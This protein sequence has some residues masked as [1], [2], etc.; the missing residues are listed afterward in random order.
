MS[1]PYVNFYTSDFLGGTSG[2]TA[3]TKGVYITL[4]CQMYESEAPLTQDWEILAR[5]AGCTKSAFKKA[6]EVLVDDGKL[7]VSEAGIW[8]SKCDKHIALRRERQNSASAA[9]KKR[10]EKIKQKQ[11]GGDKG[12]LPAQCQPEPEPYIE[13]EDTNVSSKK[14]GRSSARG[15]RLSENWVL[16][17]LWGDWA[18][19]DQGLT[20]D[21]VRLEAEKF[22]DYWHSVAGQKGVK[23]DWQATWRNW[24]RKAASDAAQ[25]A[26]SKPF[27]AIP[28][29]KSNE[30]R[31]ITE[32]LFGSGAGMDFCEGGNPSQPFSESEGQRDCRGHRHD[33]LD[34]GAFGL[35]PPA[36][37]RRM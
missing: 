1:D 35:L 30:P 23:R 5:R 21:S 14:R 34:Q 16:P 11:C 8:S 6:V 12:A 37:Q 22:R 7:T 31:S 19:A 29:G 24:A 3:A 4:L 36:D 26:R 15:T 33:G 25:R 18:V 2:M 32:R 13:K 17:K 9:A 10:W 20:E 28:G 27:K